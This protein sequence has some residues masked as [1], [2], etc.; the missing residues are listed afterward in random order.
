MLVLKCY[1]VTCLG[2]NACR[3]LATLLHGLLSQRT[4][5]T[6][7]GETSQPEESALLVIWPVRKRFAESWTLT[8]E[9]CSLPTLGF[10]FVEPLVSSRTQKSF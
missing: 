8:S 7:V 5:C 9:E 4:D 2:S 10:F 3:L 1:A 6:G